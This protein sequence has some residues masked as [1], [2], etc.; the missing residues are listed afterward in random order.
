MAKSRRGNGLGSFAKSFID[1]YKAVSTV[2][3]QKALTGL[4]KEYYDILKKNAELKAGMP[5]GAFRS[6]INGGYKG[7]SGGG[8][9]ALS[10]DEI[11]AAASERMNYLVNEKG[12]D[13]KIA[14]GIVS[15]DF[16]ESTFKPTITGDGGDSFGSFQF[17]KNGELPYFQKWAAENKR[18]PNDWKSHYDY[19]LNELQNGRHKEVYESMK[20]APDA[21]A[22][23]VTFSRGFERPNPKYA[24]EESRGAGATNIFNSFNKRKEEV[25]KDEQ[26]YKLDAVKKEELPAP[27]APAPAT[28]GALPTFARRPTQAPT[29][30]AAVPAEEPKVEEKKEEPQKESA[31]D[32]EQ[33]TQFASAD[34]NNYGMDALGLNDQPDY[35]VF[36]AEGGSVPEMPDAPMDEA[37]AA[38]LRGVK[39]MYGLE[40]ENAALPG[41]DTNRQGRLTAM[42]R[43]EGAASPEDLKQITQMVDPEGKMP[44][45]A[46]NAEALRKVYAFHASKGDK[47]GAD[48]GAAEILQ[49]SRA[50]S[51][52]L[53][54]LALAALDNG[55]LA[56][57]G[58][59]LIA[60]Y[61]QVPDGRTVEGQVD[62]NGNGMAVVKDARTGKPVQQIRVT[63]QVI[64]AAAQRLA[65]G[66]DFYT[67]LMPMAR[68][69]GKPMQHLA[70]GGLIDDDGEDDDTAADQQM[71]ADAALLAD[72]DEAD[73]PAVGASEVQYT[74][75]EKG[76]PARPEAIPYH[77]AMS[78][79]QRREVDKIN[80]A[81][82][83]EWRQA[84]IAQ[85][86][87]LNQR[88]SQEFTAG[89]DDERK[90][91]E[92]AKLKE[93]EDAKARA[94]A[95]LSD[96]QD[97]QSRDRDERS[98][99][100][101][102]TTAEMRAK[103]RDAEAEGLIAKY[104]IGKKAEEGGF[105]VG[106][107]PSEVTGSNPDYPAPAEPMAMPTFT[108]STGKKASVNDMISVDQ[109]PD[110][111]DTRF[112]REF[113]LPIDQRIKMMKVR[114]AADEER[115]LTAAELGARANKRDRSD[116]EALDKFIEN[117]EN[118]LFTKPDKNNPKKRIYIG[119][120]MDAAERNAIRKWSWKLAQFN[121]DMP[122]EEAART[123]VDLL[124]VKTKGEVDPAKFK[125]DLTP[126]EA[127]NFKITVDPKT[128]MG[129]LIYKDGLTAFNLDRETIQQVGLLRQQRIAEKWVEKAKADGDAE[130]KRKYEEQRKKVA[131][132]LKKT[133]G[134]TPMS[135]EQKLEAWGPEGTTT[136]QKMQQSFSPT[137]GLPEPEGALPRITPM[138]DFDPTAKFQRPF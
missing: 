25:A 83:D 72:D 12:V 50:N 64:Q 14:A 69:S 30:E 110:A 96:K 56:G 75:S 51:M 127:P 36:A 120:Q 136:G 102:M 79:A 48:R 132:L 40:Q 90:I 10:G 81:R 126:V 47:E 58:K 35:S 21:N 39:S 60:S 119:D 6:Y 113:A 104:A 93:I 33:P 122:P 17:N 78:P 22:A 44:P 99:Q 115:N 134:G 23:A 117:Q 45:G 27:E 137:R 103:L 89:R 74:G 37:L 133:N 63:P 105:K 125:G 66:S 42:A 31:L 7:G 32:M 16:H 15:N 77:P 82:A 13:P 55:D 135:E 49:A 107:L 2:E 20:K 123:V 108:D 94:A 65:Q 5:D 98:R 54:S 112:G 86:Q 124:A 26:G 91:F 28:A 9:K 87:E 80:S 111:V 62:A 128:G 116:L 1:A 71:S 130:L 57:A 129:R 84:I 8:T 97:R 92:M 18:D 3:N 138:R 88:R 114:G 24:R 34:D 73:L 53:G 118:G 109:V 52:K 121:P 101:G 67:H 85:R 59:A 61:N 38:A 131:E 29:A 76:I 19:T 41:T 4:R 70:G 46:A 100:G 106:A 68:Q 11:R 43:N 95:E